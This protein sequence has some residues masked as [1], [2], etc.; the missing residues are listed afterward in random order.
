MK[1]LGYLVVVALALGATTATKAQDSVL[2]VAQFFPGIG[3]WLV[4]SQPDVDSEP[5]ATA[6]V[7]EIAPVPQARMVRVVSRTKL[8]KAEV[9]T[10][11]VRVNVPLPRFRPE[12]FWFAGSYR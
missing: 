3:G 4:V 6:E 8:V 2:Q 7:V 12:A 5:A 10:D 1:R 11:N 9:E